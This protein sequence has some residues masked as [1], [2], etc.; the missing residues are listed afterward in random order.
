MDAPSRSLGQVHMESAGAGA[1]AGARRTGGP[2]LATEQ[3]DSS[4]A[5]EQRHAAGHSINHSAPVGVAQSDSPPI[6]AR[7]QEAH[8]LL[9]I[10]AA[11]SESDSG[12][13]RTKDDGMDGWGW[14]R[15]NGLADP[16][17]R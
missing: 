5:H 9:E 2:G 4:A 17:T 14:A 12:Q 16:H 3:R 15:G 13:R 11:P 6:A 10:G 8:Q 1:G 7:P